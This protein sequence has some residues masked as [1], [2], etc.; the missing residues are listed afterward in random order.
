MG[1][2]MK[3]RKKKF[4]LKREKE[5]EKRKLEVVERTKKI[6]GWHNEKSFPRVCYRES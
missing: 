6:T 1:D 2:G 5:R 4:F 3:K